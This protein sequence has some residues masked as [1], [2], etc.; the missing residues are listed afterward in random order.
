MNKHSTA[1]VKANLSQSIEKINSAKKMY[2]Q[3]PGKDFTR[4]QK[5]PF[6]EMIRIIL[7]MEGNSL[8]QELMKFFEYSPVSATSSAFCQQR[9]KLKYDA[10]HDLFVDFTSTFHSPKTYKGYRLLAADGSEIYI[11]RNESDTDTYINNGADKKGWNKL[12]LNALYD[13]QNRIFTDA[14]ITPGKKVAE[15]TSLLTMIQTLQNKHK[16]IIIADRGYES[17]QLFYDFIEQD[18]PFLIRIKSEKGNS[19]LSSVSLPSTNDFDIQMSIRVASRNNRSSLKGIEKKF[20]DPKTLSCITPENNI[21]VYKVRIIK[22]QLS[23][24]NY[25]YLLS[26]LPDTTFP[27]K[28]IKELY[29]MRWGIETAFRELKYALGLLNF[30]SKK[31]ESIKQEIFAKLI[32]YNFCSMITSHIIITQCPTNK[33]IYQLNFTRVLDICKQYFLHKMYPPNVEACIMKHILPVRKGRSYSRKMQKN[34]PM[35]FLY[36]VS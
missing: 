35:S 1:K 12:H 3:Q 29:N 4:K 10:F 6:D 21:Y 30:H 14:I 20:V 23:D 15:Q 32:M 11:P 17:Y 25:E 28:D 9:S 19:F 2:V 31:V 27:T 13:L 34:K 16:S 7:S 36:R 24:N 26:N 33:H 5:L 8:P 22:I 18:I